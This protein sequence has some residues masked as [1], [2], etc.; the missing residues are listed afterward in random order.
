MKAGAKNFPVRL[1]CGQ[2]PMVSLQVS[3]DARFEYANMDRG[4]NAAGEAE[5]VIR[6]RLKCSHPNHVEP[7]SAN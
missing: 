1:E 2:M 5:L 7:A 3:P 6:L 4:T